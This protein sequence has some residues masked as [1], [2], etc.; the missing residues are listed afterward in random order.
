VPAKPVPQTE[1]EAAYHAQEYIKEKLTI[2]ELEAEEAQAVANLRQEYA[3]RRKPHEDAR[4]EHFM[5]AHAWGEANRDGSK[6]I[7]L[8]NG[9]K[10]EW[11]MPSSSS[12]LYAEDQLE[13]IIRSLLRLKNWRKYLKVELRKNNI[14]ADLGQLQ[15]NSSTLRRL[16]RLDKTEFF[17]IG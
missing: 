4:N 16:L 11:R 3:D 6:T 1:E 5:L 8:T 12:L 14:K 13:S 2:E 7:T 10:L 17:R 15:K 9:R